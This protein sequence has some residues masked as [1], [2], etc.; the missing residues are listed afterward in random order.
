MIINSIELKDQF[1]NGLFVHKHFSL[2][3]SV[4]HC[5]IKLIGLFI[6][7]I[8][9]C[10]VHHFYSV[11]SRVL[12]STKDDQEEPYGPHIPFSYH[13]FFM[14]WFSE[15]MASCHGDNMEVVGS[16]VDLAVSAPMPQVS[17]EVEL[18]AKTAWLPTHMSP[19][20]T[21]QVMTQQVNTT[22]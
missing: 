19:N 15:D 20:I 7:N 21:A 5:V 13:D 2:S 1:Y 22:A 16:D 14:H 17:A 3:G 10:N 12:L 18:K 9:R 8:F 4:I 11:R 6:L